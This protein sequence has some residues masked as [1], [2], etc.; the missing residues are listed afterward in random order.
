MSRKLL[1]LLTAFAFAFSLIGAAQAGLLQLQTNGLTLLSPNPCPSTGCAPGQRLDFRVSYSL[2]PSGDDSPNTA[3]CFYATNGWA[4]GGSLTVA[5]TSQNEISY[6][7][8]SEQTYCSA[9]DGYE[10]IGAV[11]ATADTDISSVELNFSLRT[12]PTGALA[13]GTVLVRVISIS[14]G[15]PT[16]QPLDITGPTLAVAAASNNVFVGND[17]A[18]CG[19][20]TPCFV[21]SGSDLA[22]GL[23]TAL[24]DAVDA[25]PDNASINILGTYAI[26]SN[27]VVVAHPVIIQGVG[28]ATLTASAAGCDQP[29]LKLTAAASV[30][31]L[32]VNGG[33]CSNP[34]R[35]LIWVDSPSDAL[36]EYT[37][38]VG[39]GNAITVADNTGG[40]LVRFNDI[41]GNRGLGL[42][43][44]SGNQSG[45]LTAIANN[46]FANQAGVQASCN[47]HGRVDHN[48]WGFGVQVNDAVSDCTASN[49]KR[50]GAPIQPRASLP[51]LDAQLVQVTSNKTGAFDNKISFQVTNDASFSVYVVNHGAGSN[52]NIPFLGFGTTP[53]TPCSNFWDIFLAGAPNTNSNLDVFFKYDLNS[54]CIANVESSAYCASGDPTKY[55]LWWYDPSD[56]SATN[57]W[58][59]T[60]QKPN[61]TGAF[62][63]S[64]Q[65]TA[66]LTDSDEIKVS[67]TY[68]NNQRPNLSTDLAFVPMVVGVPFSLKSF[69]AVAYTQSVI[70]QWQTTSEA[71]ISGYYVVRSDSSS[72]VY[73]RASDFISAKGNADMGGYYTFY[74]TNLG[75]GINYYYKLEIIDSNQ[76]TIGFFGPVSAMTATATPTNTP[77]NTPTPTFTPSPTRTITPTPTITKTWTPYPTSTYYYYNYY[78]YATSTPRPRTATPF[79]PS[80]NLTRTSTSIGALI[81]QTPSPTGLL[82]DLAAMQTNVAG[83]IEPFT[84]PSPQAIALLPSQ[85]TKTA[86]ASHPAPT[87]TPSPGRV[88]FWISLASGAVLGLLVLFLSAWYLVRYRG[89][90]L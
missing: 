21:N 69:T 74:D 25:I 51:G 1:P 57:G 66:C 50:L 34:A 58:N 48:F 56:T 16:P 73:S 9:P 14:N 61:G 37:D 18:A 85:L 5:A 43:R 12:A 13:P 11:V 38:L 29:L 86:V 87:P 64:G 59:T 72:D 3:L 15:T 53:I 83:T 6:T 70:V 10:G 26:K 40:A 47:R 20:N 4:E 71:N 30:Q 78:Y 63:A 23:G 41:R 80:P 81:N 31:S 75:N 24:K 82:T 89:F 55:P 44:Q 49:G 39:G 35:D 65:T 27:T 88:A 52:E 28:N 36:I 62:G 42:L 68:D 84:T 77:T 67:L 79:T 54:A 8:T 2:K 32:N 60:G 76:Q 19:S 45:N 90:S 46:V 22:G 33:G 7:S 17:A